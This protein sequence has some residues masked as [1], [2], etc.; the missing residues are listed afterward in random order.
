MN[1]FLK[2]QTD[3][4][5]LDPEPTSSDDWL[6][7]NKLIEQ[8]AHS[9]IFL[10]QDIFNLYTIMVRKHDF[11]SGE[12]LL[13]RLPYVSLS[14]NLALYIR[15]QSLVLAE[16]CSHYFSNSIADYT[17][18]T[19]Q[20]K[21][22]VYCEQQQRIPFPIFRLI[23]NWT[24]LF[25]SLKHVKFQSA[26]GELFHLPI[27]LNSDLA[28]FLGEVVG[29]GHLTYHNIQLV[30]FSQN[31]VSLIQHLA[32]NLFGIEASI[33]GENKI[34][35]L[36]INNK[37]VVR[38]I[39]FL[40]DQPIGGPK[41]D[42][43]KEPLIIK[44]DNLLRI[45]FWSGVLDADGTYIKCLGLTS[46]SK[47]L[48]QDFGS[49]LKANNILYK[50]RSGSKYGRL[51]F[52]LIT[53][54]R[55]KREV[56]KLLIPRHPDKKKD[57]QA[58]VSSKIYRPRKKYSDELAQLKA[59]NHDLH[60]KIFNQDKILSEE[61]R[62]F[63]D[64]SLLPNFGVLHC[65][66]L[67]KDLR[68]HLS[69]TQKQLAD[70]LEIQEKMLTSYENSSDITIQ[71]LEK[72]LPLFPKHHPKSLMLFLQQNNLTLFRSRKTV[73]GLPF[74][75]S[76]ELLTLLQ[77]LEL[78]RGYLLINPQNGQ[79]EGVRAELA[80]FFVIP[81]PSGYKFSNSVIYSFAKTFCTIRNLE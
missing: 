51:A 69:W 59:T 41:Y 72:L 3:P 60:F 24:D 52:D 11:I 26:R 15:K 32:N 77:K 73:A 62:F 67:L 31:Q 61:S 39:N 81:K 55:S 27:I 44:T 35:I 4:L 36:Q 10:E 23:G 33:S 25:L 46:K 76:D 18:R 79:K 5:L 64:F 16:R 48:I 34:W 65:Q 53:S 1:N 30:D 6:T 13:Q 80:R 58:Y 19:W 21:I 42:S 63:F 17:I 45:H 38:L 54:P 12:R 68:T 40:T 22:I 28:Y 56:G 47:F 71:L 2:W 9:R 66:E 75:P 14:T 70:Y 8:E 78:R 74:Q 29:D 20:K 57:F 37:W 7:A 50:I 49:F 43:L